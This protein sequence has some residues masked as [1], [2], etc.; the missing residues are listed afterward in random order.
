[1]RRNI[2]LPEYIYMDASVAILARAWLQEDPVLSGVRCTRWTLASR[3]RFLE[4]TCGYLLA[5]PGL[6]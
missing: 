6:A 4:G 1:M 3:R 2:Y 5:S